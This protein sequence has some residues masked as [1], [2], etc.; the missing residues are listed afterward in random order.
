MAHWCRICDQHKPNEKFSGKGHRD[1]IC[2]LCSRRPI[3]ERDAIDQER[4]IHGYFEQRN[5]SKK[6]LRRL[7]SLTESV[8]PRISELAEAVLS[9]GKAKPHKRKRL[10]FLARHYPEVMNKLGAVGLIIPPE[11]YRATWHNPDHCEI[12]N[13]FFQ[14]DMDELHLSENNLVDPSEIDRILLEYFEMVG[15]ET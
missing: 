13:M 15:S 6:N 14:R 1:H 9:V 8:N 7:T 3:A 10:A 4:E 11:D 12:E 5:I 2:K